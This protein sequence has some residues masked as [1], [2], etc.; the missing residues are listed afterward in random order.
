[1]VTLRGQNWNTLQASLERIAKQLDE[2]G[3]DIEGN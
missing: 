3:I 2:F 1:M